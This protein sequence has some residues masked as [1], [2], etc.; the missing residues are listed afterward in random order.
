MA[1]CI[2]CK[3]HALIK[4]MK[5]VLDLEV[6]CLCSGHG[7]TTF[8]IWF[9]PKTTAPVGRLFSEAHPTGGATHRVGGWRHSIPSNCD[10]LHLLESYDMSDEE[11]CRRANALEEALRHISWVEPKKEEL[12]GYRGAQSTEE[13]LY[14]STWKPEPECIPLVTA[15][16]KLY[17]IETFASHCGKGK[18]KFNVWFW[19]AE[20]T[21]LSRIAEAA[22][23]AGGW[24]CG[25]TTGCGNN[26]YLLKSREVGEE[27]YAQANKIAERLNSAMDG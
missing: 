4:T 3:D 19:A 8:K 27:A 21:S 22:S 5:D 7:K 16:N 2:R 1:C 24:S 13:F 6:Q 10:G 18:N 11:A 23:R 9:R 14:T 20:V 17:G 15:M 25:L 12:R 26:V